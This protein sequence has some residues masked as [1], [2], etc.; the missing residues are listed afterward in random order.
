[1]L[2]VIKIGSEMWKTTNEAAKKKLQDEFKHDMEKYAIQIS[3]YNSSLSEQ[4]KLEIKE[5]FQEMKEEKQRRDE[6]LALAK[7]NKE[8][9]KPVKPLSSYFLFYKSEKHNRGDR[10]VTEFQV[11]LSNKWQNLSE[12]A[13]QKYIQDAA[14]SLEAYEKTLEAWEKKMINLGNLDVVRQKTIDK[15]ETKKGKD[16]K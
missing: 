16:L 9:G 14:K 8:L 13:K 3:K 10:S 11:E 4:Q 5:A 2:D 1:M 12:S 6:R 15:F 7:R